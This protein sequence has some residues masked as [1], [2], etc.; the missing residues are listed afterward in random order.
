M[1]TAAM[2]NQLIRIASRCMSL[3]IAIGIASL[4]RASDLSA[5]TGGGG[6]V[7]GGGG[8]PGASPI[9]SAGGT[10]EPAL[11]AIGGVAAGAFWVVKKIRGRRTQS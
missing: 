7:G 9:T 8:A 10:P 5:Q 2:M 4:A 6:P 3:G 1:E 11:L